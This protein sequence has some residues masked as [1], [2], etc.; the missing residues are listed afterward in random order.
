MKLAKDSPIPIHVQ[1]RDALKQVLRS[2]EYKPGDRF[3]SENEIAKKYNVSRMTVRRVMDDLLREGLIFR[4]PGKGTFVAQQKIVE[5]LTELVGFTKDME[6][7]GCTPSTKVLKKRVVYPPKKI[8]EYLHLGKGEKV[9]LLKRVRYASGEPM[10]LQT[11]YI[12]LK[13]F[14]GIEK[15]NFEKNSL[16][17]TFKKFGRPPVWAK[18]D[19]EATLIRDEEQARLLEVAPGSAGMLSERL[20]YDL[21]GN[22]IEF[23]VTLFRGDNYRFTVHLTNPEFVERRD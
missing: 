4:V 18:Q 17:D 5:K 9:L 21:E 23:T 22:P 8:Q 14:P 12:P 15:V 16:Y 11:A 3:F 20:T 6:R 7:K 13:F 1:L 19:M 2:G 10:A